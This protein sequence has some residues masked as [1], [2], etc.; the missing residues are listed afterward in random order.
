MD[1]P[2]ASGPC[3]HKLLTKVTTNGNPEVEQKR[4]KL[5]TKYESSTYPKTKT[6]TKA[7]TKPTPQQQRPSVEIVEIED[8]ADYR[9][10]V[11]PC[12]PQHILE[13][14]DGSDDDVDT[15]APPQKSTTSTKK[16]VNTK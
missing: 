14:T 12:N 1:S 3:K 8:E 9:A 2:E 6:M 13:A 7:A 16:P 5:E 4:K 15:T 11:P 10:S